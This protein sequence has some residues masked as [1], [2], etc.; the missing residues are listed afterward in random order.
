MKKLGSWYYFK[1]FE[2]DKGWI[3]EKI[4]ARFPSVIV[5]KDKCNVRSGP[6]ARFDVLFAVDKGVPFKEL[7]RK[8]DWV[9]IRHSDGDK[10]WIHRKLVW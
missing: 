8:G 5:I 4:V 2:G 3:S 1:D 10:G 7:E 6:G 9:H